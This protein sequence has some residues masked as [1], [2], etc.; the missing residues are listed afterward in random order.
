[1]MMMGSGDSDGET[2]PSQDSSH[3][4]KLLPLGPFYRSPTDIA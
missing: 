1:M 2:P 4:E 3:Q